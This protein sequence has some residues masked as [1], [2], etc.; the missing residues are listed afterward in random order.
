MPL[1]AWLLKNYIV[2]VLVSANPQYLRQSSR[3]QSGST[4]EIVL[5]YCYSRKPTSKLCCRWLITIVVWL[6][7][8][9]LLATYLSLQ[10]QHIED[11]SGHSNLMLSSLCLAESFTWNSVAGCD[12]TFSP[13][14][15]DAWTNSMIR[16][17]RNVSKAR[18]VCQF[19]CTP[20]TWTTSTA[21]CHDFFFGWHPLG[22]LRLVLLM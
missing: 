21:F 3:L 17:I 10:W 7:F 8:R 9:N 20:C 15:F 16:M 19:Y 1:W 11:L 5:G 22:I 6:N 18:Y 12:D 14:T 2:N 13:N 4:P